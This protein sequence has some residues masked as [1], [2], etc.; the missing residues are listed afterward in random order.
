MQSSGPR[1]SCHPRTKD[2]CS[3]GLLGCFKILTPQHRQIDECSTLCDPMDL[4]PARLLCPWNSSGK[5]TGVGSHSL[6]Q[7][8]FLTQGSNPGLLHHRQILYHL[9]H[10]GSPILIE[11]KE[12]NTR[13]VRQLEAFISCPFVQIQKWTHSNKLASECQ[14]I[15]NGLTQV[16][17]LLQMMSTHLNF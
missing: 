14:L 4:Y 16:T 3:V 9:S 2:N 15:K 1:F 11:S 12:I 8:I 13:G 17:T 7:G 6:L 10:Q 5:N